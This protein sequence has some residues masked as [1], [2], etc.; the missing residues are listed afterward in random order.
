MSRHDI[1][2]GIAITYG[3]TQE[4]AEGVVDD[5]HRDIETCKRHIYS[6]MM[7][8]SPVPR[9]VARTNARNEIAPIAD[10]H[11]DAMWEWADFV[12]AK[13]G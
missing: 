2:R 5:L 13:C 11:F 8:R 7:P 4:E 3:A 9:D 10:V 6:T 1:A 12:I